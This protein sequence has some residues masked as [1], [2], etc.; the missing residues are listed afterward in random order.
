M[1]TEEGIANVSNRNARNNFLAAGMFIDKKADNDSPDLNKEEG[2][3]YPEEKNDTEKALEAF[4]GDESACKM[5]Y[6]Q[7][8][9]EDEKPE[10]VSFKGTNYDKEFNITL[11]SAQSNI[12]KVFSQPPILR[13]EDVGANFG[14]DLMKNAYDFYNSVTQNE[15]LILERVFRELF[16]YWYEPL[17]SDFSILPLTYETDTTPAD[18]LGKDNLSQMVAI[19]NSANSTYEQK[20]N[21]CKVLFGL[22]DLEINQMFIVQN[23]QS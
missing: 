21:Y 15:R 14:A 16:S 10:F 11:E 2:R 3:I 22:T 1:S 18:R 17:T 4:Q 9:S 13:A 6:I 5:L 7:V 19:L 12:G 8:E 20:K 23:T